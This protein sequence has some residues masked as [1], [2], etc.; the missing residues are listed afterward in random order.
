MSFNPK[1]KFHVTEPEWAALV[2]SR[3]QLEQSFASELPEPTASLD[4]QTQLEQERDMVQQQ[5]AEIRRLRAQVRYLQAQ[6]VNPVS[7]ANLKPALARKQTNPVILPHAT[8]WAQLT[9]AWQNGE[10]GIRPW[11]AEPI[12][13]QRRVQVELPHFAR[14]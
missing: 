7:P 9:P 3:Q 1:R 13:S 14:R 6:L 10:L 4:S 2:N 8:N 11:Q 12:R 5:A